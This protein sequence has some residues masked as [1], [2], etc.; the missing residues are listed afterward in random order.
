MY[1]IL[2]LLLFKSKK[3]DHRKTRYAWS[4]RVLFYSS[5]VLKSSAGWSCEVL[6]I[7]GIGISELML[8]L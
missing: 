2:R 3:G 8:D 1:D 7:R 4:K 6:L 5:K